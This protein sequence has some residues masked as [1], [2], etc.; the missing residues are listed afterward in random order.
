MTTVKVQLNKYRALRD[1]TYP[2]V[3]QII[4]RRH[5]RVIYSP[6]HLHEETF[7]VDRSRVVNRRGRRVSGLQEINAY[8]DATLQNLHQSIGWFESQPGE[9]SVLD[10]VELSHSRKDCRFVVPY[11][12]KLVET[13]TKEG[14]TGT[15]NAYRSTLN[16]LLR[17]LRREDLLRFEDITVCWLNEFVSYLHQS[18]LK[19]NTVNFYLRILRAVYNRAW[20]EDIPGAQFLSPFHKVHIGM[21][22]TAKR[23]VSKECIML[24]AR[25]QVMN[26][27][28]LELA[29]DLFLFSFY[30]RG[31]PFVDMAFLRKSDISEDTIRYA[32][33]KTG[34]PLSIKVTEPLRELI[35]KYDNGREYVFPLLTPGSKSLYGQYQS[36]LRRYNRQ[37]CTLSAKL[38]LPYRLTSYAARHSWATIARSNG[39]PVSVISEGLGHSSEK[40]TYTYLA[41]LDPSVLNAANERVT[42]LCVGFPINKRVRNESAQ[43]KIRK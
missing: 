38:K 19:T 13:I 30:S 32:R 12:R 11:L 39:V 18:G 31:M 16:C 29:R 36:A 1:G 3:F 14:R 22:R 43:K 28:S 4:H 20:R 41:A 33:R 5:K 40:V 8:I 25:E 42:D 26:D 6:Y 10:I 35:S 34:Q 21:M 9:Y 15:A 2:L 7:D 23:A 27:S 24:I 17:F 37:L